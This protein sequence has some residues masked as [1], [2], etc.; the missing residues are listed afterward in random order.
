LLSP[1]SGSG[2]LLL[3]V[4]PVLSAAFRCHRPRRHA[5]LARAGG[6]S[7]PTIG[8]TPGRDRHQTVPLSPADDEQQ[9]E[10][11]A[12]IGSHRS[13]SSD[14]PSLEQALLPGAGT[15][16]PP[17]DE[18]ALDHVDEPEWATTD[19]QRRC[20]ALPATADALRGHHS[21]GDPSSR[22]NPR[23]ATASIVRARVRW[24]AVTS[25]RQRQCQPRPTPHDGEVAG[26]GATR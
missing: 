25:N 13:R 23:R 22:S 8:W 5:R 15:V 26:S 20:H 10:L 3:D 21:K 7:S 4:A 12:P 1:R 6:R 11:P 9:L 2:L 24:A 19:A 16:A 17:D 14:V 18:D